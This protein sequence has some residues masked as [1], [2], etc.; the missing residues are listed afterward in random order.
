MQPCEK[1]LVSGPASVK[2]IQHMFI[3]Q[4]I[5][6]DATG[7]ELEGYHFTTWV[8]MCNVQ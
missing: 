8:S 2:I 6:N 4:L 1:S 5:A 7:P 3:S